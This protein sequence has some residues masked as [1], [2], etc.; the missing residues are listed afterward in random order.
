MYNCPK[1]AFENSVTL[2]SNREFLKEHRSNVSE[3]L[4]STRSWDVLKNDAEKMN[5]PTST[6]I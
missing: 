6:I 2:T 1:D 3:L 4:T 5:E